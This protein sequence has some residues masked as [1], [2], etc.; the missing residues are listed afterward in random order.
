MK[1]FDEGQ[2]IFVKSE[3]GVKETEVVEHTL[4]MVERGDW[5]LVSLRHPDGW[6]INLY[7]KTFTYIYLNF[8]EPAGW[9]FHGCA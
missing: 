1:D 7:Q 2:L 8:P 5:K 9:N 6:G 4:E 3:S